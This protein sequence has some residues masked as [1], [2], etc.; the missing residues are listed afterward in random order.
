MNYIGW[1]PILSYFFNQSTF[2]MFRWKWLM[3][4]VFFLHCQIKETESFNRPNVLIFLVDDLG[5]NDNSVGFADSLSAN[6]RFYHTPN[7]QKLVGR[8]IKFTQAYSASPV[9][10]PTRASILT[11]KNPLRTG[12][13]NWIPGEGTPPAGQTR[14][15]LP[16]WN[17]QGLTVTDT[18]LP[19]LF[20][21][22]GYLTAHIGKAHFANRGTPGENPQNLGFEINI[23]GSHIGHPASFYFPYGDS[24][25]THHVTGLEEFKTDR[26]Y[27][28]E[29]LTRKA[30][31]F[32]RQAVTVQRPFFLH[33]AHYAVH[34]PIQPDSSR[35]AR[36]AG[37]G[38]LTANVNYAT[39]VESMDA[40]LG[41]LLQVIDELGIKEETLVIFLSDNGGLATHA[42]PPTDNQ[43]L[44]GGKGTCREG[45]TRIPLV[46]S[47]PGQIKPR[48]ERKVQVVTDDL[49]PTLASICGLITPVADGVDLS[50]LWLKEQALPVRPLV[51]HWPHY[52]ADS[53]LRSRH[54]IIQPF[55]SIRLGDWKY[56][57]RYE[58]GQ[59][60]LFDLSTD[61]GE[62]NNLL[63][64]NATK[65][66][67]LSLLLESYLRR[68]NALMLREWATGKPL[69]YAVVRVP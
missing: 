36:Y 26:P 50:P 10:S 43:P 32:I 14:Y 20:K 29:A 9:C 66:Q 49:L 16:L 38:R 23:A 59:R 40:S 41:R 52:W 63:I 69:D 45:S 44:A 67:E 21:Q 42:G 48:V 18:T 3:V 12:I 17:E 11:G 4:S 5:W 33:L 57:Y 24:A 62:T 35:L 7:L 54:T 56:I 13:T 28:D 65:A 1:L 25:H 15:N 31:S 51:W 30:E 47:W 64:Q 2:F 53:L 68:H 58:D 60:E 22:R 6:N 37:S 39:M 8:G 55:S 61:E 34:T 46:V 27:L 19:K